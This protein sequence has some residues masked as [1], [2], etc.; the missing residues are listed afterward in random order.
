MNKQRF[1]LLVVALCSLFSL[2]AQEVNHCLPI[3]MGADRIHLIL[4]HTF[5]KKVGILSNHTGVMSADPSMHVVDKLLSLGVNVTTIYS[6]EHGFR[7][8][9]DAGAKIDSS[10]DAKTGLPIISLYGSN[11]KPSAKDLENVDVVLFDMQDVGCRFYTYISSLHYLMEACAENGKKVI[12]L[13]RPN[14][15]DEV[16]GPVRKSDDF[17]S[18]VGMHHIPILH[19]LTLGEAAKMING[20]GWLGKDKYCDLVVVPMYGWSHGMRYS[21]PIPPSPNLKSD[22]AIALYPSLCFFEGT[23]WSVGRGTSTPFEIIGYPSSKCGAFYFTPKS[24]P[25]ATNPPQKDKKCYGMDLRSTH[26][27]PSNINLNYL[28]DA[29]KVSTENGIDFFT[30]SRMMDLLSGTDQLRKDIIAG[31]SEEEIKKSWQQDLNEYISLRYKYLLYPETRAKYI[32]K[33]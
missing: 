13:D 18:F 8:D 7:G 10:V 23:S 16:D 4:P 27:P 31:K 11:R 2:H 28:I 22:N 20:E 33:Q 1:W 25:G 32:P 12:V 26:I 29:Y 30:R 3:E 24:V 17:K 21:V 15:N 19:G 9:A 5:G 14:P 6:P